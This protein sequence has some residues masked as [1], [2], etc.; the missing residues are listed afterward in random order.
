MEKSKKG[1]EKEYHVWPKTCFYPY[2]QK[3]L[4][5]NSALPRFQVMFWAIFILF[6]LTQVGQF[7]AYILISVHS[8]LKSVHYW[9]KI[10]RSKMITNIFQISSRIS[11][12]F[13]LL[14]LNLSGKHFFIFL[15]SSC[16]TL[17]N[18]MLTRKYGNSVASNFAS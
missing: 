7:E 2:L 12:D 11:T 15:I 13:Q 4:N 9:R 14:C 16:L 8:Y 18:K 17:L 1:M 6:I 5:I 10:Q 3:T